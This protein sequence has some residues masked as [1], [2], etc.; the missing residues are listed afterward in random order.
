[1]SAILY[2][3]SYVYFKRNKQYSIFTIPVMAF[4]NIVFTFEHGLDVSASGSSVGRAVD[5]SCVSRKQAS[6]GRWFKPD[7]EDTFYFYFFAVTCV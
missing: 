5:C 1:M 4:V 3:T 7:P 2:K 6:I